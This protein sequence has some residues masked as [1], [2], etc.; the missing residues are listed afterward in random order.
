V[1]LN[2]YS[3]IREVQDNEL[4]D[5]RKLKA[6]SEKLLPPRS[7]LRKIILSEPDYIPRPEGLVKLPLFAKMLDEELRSTY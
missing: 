4:L 1:A 3:S 6:L 5:M 7:L 2:K